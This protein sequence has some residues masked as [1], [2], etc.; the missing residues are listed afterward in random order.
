MENVGKP[1]VS[2]FLG[3]PMGWQS[4]RALDSRDMRF[5]GLGGGGE[6]TN[7]M[8][9]PKCKGDVMTIERR[10]VRLWHHSTHFGTGPRSCFFLLPRLSVDLVRPSS[11]L[12]C[13]ISRVTAGKVPREAEGAVG[14]CEFTNVRICLYNLEYVLKWS[15]RFDPI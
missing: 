6:I 4:W 10:T 12:R 2:I 8:D 7:G 1:A 5:H 3:F 15:H 13:M 9:Q 11:P 14:W